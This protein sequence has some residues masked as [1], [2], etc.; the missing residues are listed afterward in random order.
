MTSTHT[1][2][3]TTFVQLSCCLDSLE[4]TPCLQVAQVLKA[5]RRMQLC[6]APSPSA[7]LFIFLSVPSLCVCVCLSTCPCISF[8]ACPLFYLNRHFRNQYAHSLHSYLL[9]NPRCGMPLFTHLKVI[10][11]LSQIKELGNNPHEMAFQGGAPAVTENLQQVCGS[12]SCVHAHT[13]TCIC[14]STHTIA[15]V[16]ACVTGVLKQP[17]STHSLNYPISL[18]QVRGPVIRNATADILAIAHFMTRCVRQSSC[19]CE[20]V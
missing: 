20:A 1:I 2:R 15:F 13:Q 4:S 5:G 7:C 17:Q 19:V 6:Y 9:S 16:T 12:V 14:A 18:T 8:S 10:A 3:A 11:Q